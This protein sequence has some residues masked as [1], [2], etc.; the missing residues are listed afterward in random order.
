MIDERRRNQASIQAGARVDQ[1]QH[2]PI[3]LVTE[4]AQ[5][6]KGAT[7]GNRRMVRSIEQQT[8]A[9]LAVAWCP[10]GVAAQNIANRLI[11]DVIF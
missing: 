8:F 5:H 2:G 4:F 9:D 10:P 1:G 6:R 7:A 11:R 3:E